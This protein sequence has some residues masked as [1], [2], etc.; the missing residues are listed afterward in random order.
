MYVQEL[1]RLS[2]A[3]VGVSAAE[4]LFIQGTWGISSKCEVV[5]N[6][7]LNLK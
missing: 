7:I 4:Y 2:D 5:Y 3:G 1:R 6:N